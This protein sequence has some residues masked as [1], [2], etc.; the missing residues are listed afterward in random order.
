[1]LE[2]EKIDTNALKAF[3]YKWISVGYMFDIYYLLFHIKHTSP[4]ST[5]KQAV[6][7][8]F[9]T[10][11]ELQDWIDFYTKNFHPTAT[12]LY[13]LKLECQKIGKS[14]EDGVY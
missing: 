14:A 12:W 2:I 10:F 11:S 6:C 3:F 4:P 8:F 7:S 13:F 1:M 5:H 9:G